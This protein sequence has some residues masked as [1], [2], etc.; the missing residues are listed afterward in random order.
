MHNKISVYS[1]PLS[2]SNYNSYFD[3]VD[4]TVSLGIKNLETFN[5]FEL[6]TPDIEFAKRL[7]E[8]A[9]KKGVKI[10]CAS[11]GI[12]LVNDDNEKKM[13]RALAYAD[14]AKALGSPYFHHT[15]AL[16]ISDPDR[17]ERNREIYF[18][19]GLR[20]IEKVYD[21]CQSIGIRSVYEDQGYLFNGVQGFKRLM[22][23]T[24][25]N[26]GVV[27][28]FGNCLF[29]DEPI[30][31]FIPL[32]K[33]RVVN[34]HVKDYIYTDGTT[35]D[36]MDNEFITAKKNYLSDCNFG[37]GIVN[38]D[39][40]FEELR[41]IGYNGYYSVESVPMGDDEQKTFIKNVEYLCKY[42]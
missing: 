6:K 29:V 35:R 17:T 11:L 33:D 7:R 36:K 3:V 32:V 39:R 41:K 38:F 23:A 30:E 37:E 9:D 27:V 5:N 4:H 26:F 28:D 31:D 18:S 19:R 13:E 12:D 2:I 1:P 20:A 10:V 40:A 16:N 15:V 42:L 21:Y 25:R 24:D 14:V 8:Y 22:D 34:V